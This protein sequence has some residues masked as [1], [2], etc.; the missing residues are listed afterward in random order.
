MLYK[1]SGIFKNLAPTIIQPNTCWQQ[2]CKNF[3]IPYSHL[4]IRSVTIFYPWRIL[5]FKIY[6][7][8]DGTYTVKHPVLLI[9]HS[10]MPLWDFCP[11]LIWKYLRKDKCPY[12][13]NTS[14]GPACMILRVEPSLLILIVMRHMLDNTCLV[15]LL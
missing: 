9:F 15:D 6:E 1:K 7:N 4:E 8:W 11:V 2:K 12:T 13:S 14:L 5:L 10:W 3:T